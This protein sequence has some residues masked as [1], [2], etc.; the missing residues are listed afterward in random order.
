MSS[1]TGN[2]RRSALQMSSR[3]SFFH[4]SGPLHSGQ[5]RIS[6]SL[7]SI[8]APAGLG[9]TREKEVVELGRQDRIDPHVPH[10]RIGECGAFYGILLGHDD[11]LGAGELQLLR[12][13]G[14][15]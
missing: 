10:A 7:G 3:A 13:V 1:F 8:S 6:S 9:D 15:M 14:V 4:T 5:T 12:L 2:A 11:H